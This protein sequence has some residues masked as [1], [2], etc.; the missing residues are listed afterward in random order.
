MDS[1]DSHKDEPVDKSSSS[2]SSSSNSESDFTSQ[3]T[4]EAR[5]ESAFQPDSLIE[6]HDV[7]TEEIHH[8]TEEVKVETHPPLVE[9]RVE[10]EV[11][12]EPFVN[13]LSGAGKFPEEQK[14]VLSLP[15]PQEE[16]GKPE[17]KPTET[18]KP[19]QQPQAMLNSEPKPV[20]RPDE[21]P[22]KLKGDVENETQAESI[23]VKMDNSVSSRKQS[24]SSRV[25]E[26]GRS[27]CAK[28]SLF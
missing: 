2:N 21:S 7:E 4:S 13:P 14:E 23:P 10:D 12:K 3:F 11:A 20:A 8:V 17:E 18:P 26:E 5:G 1:P 24:T 27:T 19:I 15:P 6:K 22:S 16:L 28:C 9:S 25:P